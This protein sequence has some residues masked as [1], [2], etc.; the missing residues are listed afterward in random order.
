MA[1]LAKPAS[2]IPPGHRVVQCRESRMGSRRLLTTAS[3]ADKWLG[4]VYRLMVMV[5][6]RVREPAWWSER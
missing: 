4:L 2:E 1:S 5:G 3:L 6:G